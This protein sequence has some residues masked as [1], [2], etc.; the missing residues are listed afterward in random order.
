MVN[1]NNEPLPNTTVVLLDLEGNEL[2]RQVTDIDAHY[3]FKVKAFE[4]YSIKALKSGFSTLEARF[5]SYQANELVYKEVLRLS[6]KVS[7]I[8][9]P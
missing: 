3:N 2:D 8:D 6:P 4:N 5:S 7:A 9:K 1:E